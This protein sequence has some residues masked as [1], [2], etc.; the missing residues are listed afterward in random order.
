MSMRYRNVLLVPLFLMTLY[1]AHPAQAAT[2]SEV[3]ITLHKHL[4]ATKPDLVERQGN[5][6][7]QVKGTPEANDPF[8]VYN[9][10]A[11]YQDERVKPG[12]N[13]KEWIKSFANMKVDEITRYAFPVVDKLTTN[14]EGEATT[15]VPVEKQAAYLFVE[16]DNQATQEPTAPIM[17]LLPFY[18][19][20]TGQELQTL[21]LYLKNTQPVLEVTQPTAEIPKTGAMQ[22]DT[23]QTVEKSPWFTLPNTGSAAT[24]VSLIGGVILL[25]TTGVIYLKHKKIK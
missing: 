21:H 25:L 9:A 13:A 15:T 17:V 22:T 24:K 10:T 6:E 11:L 2:Y 1:L 20:Q 16:A 4:F 19:P 8:I 12:F 23:I 18:Q 14:D 7:E 3:E 5:K